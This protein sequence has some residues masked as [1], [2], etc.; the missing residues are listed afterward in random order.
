MPAG[1]AMPE[2][3]VLLLLALAIGLVFRFLVG[4]AVRETFAPSSR[5]GSCGGRR[6]AASGTL[7]R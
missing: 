3:V 7:R 1:G 6:R 4:L 2:L 5:G